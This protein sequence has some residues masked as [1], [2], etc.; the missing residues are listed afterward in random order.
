MD[1]DAIEP[2]RIKKWGLGGSNRV[3]AQARSPMP[4]DEKNEC[5]FAHE[6][7]NRHETSD[8]HSHHTSCRITV[9]L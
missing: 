5:V 2:S 4:L 7:E 1:I 3:P 8:P 9:Q 6:G